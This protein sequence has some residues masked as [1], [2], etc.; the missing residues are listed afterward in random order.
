M[1]FQAKVSNPD[2]TEIALSDEAVLPLGDG[3]KGAPSYVTGLS[4]PSVTS[5]EKRRLQCYVALIIGDVLAIGAGFILASLIRDGVVNNGQAMLQAQL[6]VPIFLTFALYN[7]AYSV[8]ALLRPSRSLANALK[9][10]AGAG[11]ALLLFT[12]FTK[13][14]AFYS[15]QMF[16]TG[17]LSAAVAMVAMRVAVRSFV[18]W[19]CGDRI[20]NILIVNDGGPE[21]DLGQAYLVDAQAQELRPDLGDPH[22]L[23]RLAQWFTPMDRV[24]ISCAEHRRVAWAM[25]LK[26]LAVEGEIIDETVELMGA[27][28]A[29]HAGGQGFLLVS[30]RP[31][32][33]RERAIKRG[34][35]L[36]LTIPALIVLAPLMIVVA[37]AVRLQDGGPSLF[38]QQRTGR[39][40][41]MFHVYKFRSMRVSQEDATGNRSA[42]KDDDRLTVLGRFLRRSSIDELPQLFNVLKGDMSLVGPRPH[43]LGAR[44]GTKLFWEVDERYWQRHMLK[45]GLTGLAQV[46]GYR[47]AT[48]C[49]DDLV[50]RLQS[51]LQ[52]LDGWSLWRDV[53]ILIATLRVVVHHRAF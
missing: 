46:R 7:G 37:I 34:F 10:L 48:D 41:R 15:R 52:Y 20:E 11:I 5:L 33:L 8:A 17:I 51:D 44:A 35:D 22:A 16:G 13:T 1:N 50:L 39:A 43:P 30:H 49:E 24:I 26:G 18:R 3:E 29:R 32:N 19:R 28:G 4:M 42:S 23:D 2:R 21:L 27:L 47:G 12:F 14:G 38:I 9:A 40:S 6:I 31:L 25:A 36:V 53:G 45:P